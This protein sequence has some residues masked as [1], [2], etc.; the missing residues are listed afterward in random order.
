M[1]V[2]QDSQLKFT[3]QVPKARKSRGMEYADAR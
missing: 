3:A 2:A 1:H